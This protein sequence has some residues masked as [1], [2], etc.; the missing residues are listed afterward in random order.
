MVI[1]TANVEDIRNVA[2]Q[3]VPAPLADRLTDFIAQAAGA[4]AGKRAQENIQSRV[5]AAKVSVATFRTRSQ[6]MA[7]IALKVLFPASNAEMYA[8]PASRQQSSS[9]Y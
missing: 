1:L 2:R 7:L 6:Q 5:R 4:I 3:L 9:S 8:K